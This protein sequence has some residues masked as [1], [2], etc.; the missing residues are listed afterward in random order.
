MR[1]LTRSPSSPETLRTLS[2]L[3]NVQP[4]PFDIEDRAS[5]EAAFAGASVVFG[6]SHPHR[7]AMLADPTTQP[8]PA[9]EG[10][11][12]QEQGKR[13]AD[14]AKEKGVDIF[15]WTTLPPVKSHKYAGMPQ[16]EDKIA[17]EGHIKSIGLKAV[18]V[19]LGVRSMRTCDIAY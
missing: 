3:A 18:F 1:A 11:S 19:Q 5:V 12:E 4:F 9:A 15:V 16:F 7:E 10:L 13:L 14:M 8:P 2:G 17:V 6:I